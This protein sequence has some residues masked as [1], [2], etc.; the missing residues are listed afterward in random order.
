MVFFDY[1]V[2]SLAG[3]AVLAVLFTLFKNKRVFKTL[4]NSSIWGLSLLIILAATNKLTGITINITPYTLGT[5]GIFGVP[6]VICVVL[7]KIIWGI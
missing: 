5:S 7:T 3:I 1:F 2:I 6:G 4:L